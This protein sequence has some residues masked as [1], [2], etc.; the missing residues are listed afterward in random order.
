MP[1]IE[2]PDMK[3]TKVIQFIIVFASAL[4]IA[5]YH[6][7]M[8]SE[9]SQFHSLHYRLNYIPIIL[10]AIWFEIQGGIIAPILI[11]FLYLPFA[12]WGFGMDHTNTELNIYLEFVLYNAVG[13]IAGWLVH[14]RI[15]AEEKLEESKRLALLGEFAAG[16]VHEI[17][18]P[19][20]T[21]EGAVELLKKKSVGLNVDEILS[22][23]HDEAKRL[24]KFA[25][26]FLS[27]AKPQV[28]HKIETDITKLLEVTL[29]RI[30]MARGDEMP[31]V[32]IY[33]PAD[34]S[35]CVCDPLQIEQVLVNVIGNAVEAAGKTGKIK[36]SVADIYHLLS[37][38]I[39]DS[40][41]GVEES[42]RTKIFEPF[43]SKRKGGTGLGLPI[44]KKIVEAH[45][46][47]IYCE[48]S[49]LGGAKF[50][51]EVPKS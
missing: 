24:D 46:G 5:F 36:I 33:A 49:L 14:L 23:V 25:G 28:T 10:S 22:I 37:I 44:S 39:E 29:E 21:I 48:E 16:V 26:E 32:E 12:I 42:E 1:A 13:W 19:V 11:T 34:I 43:R 35:S 2:S 47:R 4:L 30:G 18:N 8:I 27:L 3:R 51:I 9:H 41:P 6:F 31:Q 7:K 50:V 38:S 17:K 20:Q 15:K 40:G 45:G